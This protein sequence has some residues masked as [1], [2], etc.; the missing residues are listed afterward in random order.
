MWHASCSEVCAL[1]ARAGTQAYMQRMRIDWLLF[2]CAH[3]KDHV[4]TQWFL[5]VSSTAC[6]ILN[7]LC[8]CLAGVLMRSEPAPTSLVLTNY[9]RSAQNPM[10]FDRCVKPLVDTRSL[11]ISCVAGV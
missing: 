5:Q 8:R 4:Y 11:T 6:A 3:V 9:G 10:P 1:N 2:V 7:Y